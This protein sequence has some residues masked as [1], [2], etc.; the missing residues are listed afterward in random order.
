M[1]SIH[2]GIPTDESVV[3]YKY[4]IH[5]SY[6]SRYN[7]NDEIRIP[8]QE[9]LCTLPS[10]SYLYIEGQLLKSDGTASGINTKFVN[11]GIAFLF[12][13]IRYEVNGFVVDVNTKPGLTSTMKGLASFNKSEAVKYENAGW[14]PGKESTIVKNGRFSVCIPLKMLLGFAE[15]YKKVMV[16]IFQ[17]L[18][19]IR[20][21]SDKSALKCVVTTDASGTKKCSAD[22][23]AKV[24]IDKIMWKVPHIIPGLHEEV[25]L[26]KFIEKGKDIIVPYR[27]WELHSFPSLPNTTRHTWNVKTSTK[28]ESPRYIIMGF[29]TDR[30][31]LE[32]DSSEFDTCDFS[33]I[34]LFLNN[35]RYPYENLNISFAN[36]QFATLYEMFTQFRS[37][38]Y[39]DYKSETD[40]TPSQFAKAFPLI[41]VDCSKQK[42]GFQTQSVVLRV[43]F[44]T[45]TAILANTTAHILIIS[46][47]VFTYN[48]LTKSV[49]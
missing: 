9:D 24:V 21:N 27:T 36:N 14:F 4:H 32:A 30:E 15:D 8:L 40:I 13:E 23:K 5:E 1:F 22:E 11:N 29:Q 33:N 25:N 44:E 10:E 16:N 18:I 35:E 42:T 38:Y 7:N 12:S 3:S 17:E 2:E 28:L 20:S 34:R 43:E 46:D 31:R 39:Y 19:L 49:K 6:T 45:N 47:R 48:P 41:I 26:T 37:A